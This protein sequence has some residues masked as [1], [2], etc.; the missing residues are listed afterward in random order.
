MVKIKEINA[1]EILNA[2][3]LPTIEATVTLSDGKIGVASCPKG[4]KIANYEASELKDSDEKRFEGDGMLKAIDNIANIIKPALVGKDAENQQDIDK[5]MINL[6]GT[7][8]KSRIG[9]NAML[10]VS[11]AVAKAS[12]ESSVLP[13]FLYLRQFIKKEHESLK[14]PV[15]IFNLISGGK[16]QNNFGDFHEFLVV[17]ASSKPYTE[18]IRIGTEISKS[19]R[20]IL[21]SKNLKMNDGSEEGFTP[22]FTTN[23]EAF[24]FIK[25]AVEEA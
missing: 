9:A 20:R 23:K 10:T 6:D 15:P 25:Q 3:G 8:N 16:K 17:P 2:K 13:L 14:I 1:R 7:Q 24:Y 18:S 21:E 5:T 19:L 11:I 4:E 22:S 12:A